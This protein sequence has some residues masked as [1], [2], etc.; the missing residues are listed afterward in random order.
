MLLFLG[1][2]RSVELGE[3]SGGVYNFVDFA[4]FEPF[5]MFFGQ[6]KHYF[7]EKSELIFF[8]ENAR[9]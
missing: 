1:N 6:N 7:Y 8:L 4:V 9:F 3:K 5:F 2:R